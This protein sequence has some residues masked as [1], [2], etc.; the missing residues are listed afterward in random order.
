MTDTLSIASSGLRVGATRQAVAADNIVRIGA[1]AAN[2][3][4]PS[5]RAPLG[6]K[7]VDTVSLAGGGV[8]ARVLPQPSGEPGS[9]LAG[10]IVDARATVQAYRVSAALIRAESEMQG[11]LLDATG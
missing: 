1:N 4:N 11:Q 10:E 3:A 9:D 2:A 8:A 5:D 6:L 7:Q